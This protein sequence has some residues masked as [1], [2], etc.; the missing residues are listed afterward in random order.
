M[1]DGLTALRPETIAA[2]QAAATAPAHS[3]LYAAFEKAQNHAIKMGLAP[4]VSSVALAN[5]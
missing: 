3:K 5:A 4:E 1:L 2:Q